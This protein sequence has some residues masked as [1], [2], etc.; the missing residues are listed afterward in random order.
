MQF[1]KATNKITYPN[2]AIFSVLSDN[3]SLIDYIFKDYS[4]KEDLKD[5]IGSLAKSIS[6]I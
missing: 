5:A 3:K 1:V 2:Q 6:R 4:Q